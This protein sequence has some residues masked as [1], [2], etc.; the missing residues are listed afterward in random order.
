MATV[1]ARRNIG[2]NIPEGCV[3]DAKLFRNGLDVELKVDGKTALIGS[4]HVD[5]YGGTNVS[6]QVAKDLDIGDYKLEVGKVYQWIVQDRS[7]YMKIGLHAIHSLHNAYVTNVTPSTVVKPILTDSVGSNYEVQDTPFIDAYMYVSD[8]SGIPHQDVKVFLMD[9]MTSNKPLTDLARKYKY[10]AV[11][12]ASILK[13][14]DDWVKDCANGKG[15][16]IEG[17][18][19]LVSSVLHDVGGGDSRGTMAQ[20]YTDDEELADS[21]TDYFSS[22]SEVVVE[23]KLEKNYEY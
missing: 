14:F 6:F 3:I 13:A 8:N 16:L 1:I 9:F 18:W 19:Y 7:L 5:L 10:N 23:C 15:S 11:T 20:R 2:K 12:I 22:N 21:R 17:E 4:R